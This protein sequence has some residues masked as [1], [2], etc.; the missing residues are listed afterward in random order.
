MN[1][2]ANIT[3]KELKELLTPGTIIS[4]VIVVVM[5]SALGGMMSDQTESEASPK[6]IGVVF[7]E[8]YNPNALDTVIYTG[9]SS[10]VTLGDLI[11]TAYVENYSVTNPEEY[12]HIMKSPFSDSDAVSKELQDESYDAV[13]AIPGDIAANVAAH[14]QTQLQGYYTYTNGGLFSTVT[15]T[16]A[17]NIINKMS[18]LLSTQIIFDNTGEDLNETKFV[19][20]PL[21]PPSN[22]KVDTNHTVINGKLCENV[23]PA[24]IYSSMMGQNMMIPVIVMIVIVMVGSVVISSMGNEKENKT[25][26]TLLTM[27][28]KRTTIVSG[29]LLAAAIMGLVYGI[30]Y[31]AGMMM[32]TNGMTS[33]LGGAKVDLSTYGLVMNPLDWLLLMVILFLSIFSALGI[34]MILGAFTKNYKMAQTMTLPIS[35]LALIPMFI[36][37]FSSWNVLPLIGKILLFIIP[38]THPMMGMDNLMFGNYALVFGGMA[39]LLVFDLI[40]VLVTVKIYNSDIL[41]TGLGQT[42][43]VSKLSKLFKSRKAENEDN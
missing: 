12:I 21:V 11:K 19:Q 2:L 41:I 13:I 26:E 16:I 39:Y 8:T 43:T 37:M 15:G 24:E 34:C 3:K 32:Y 25:L 22:S 33:G 42:K 9:L 29:K 1:H 38:F 23:T 30:C 18:S 20:L 10:N 28:I 17:A 27:P 40:M 36:F 6:N 7:G 35:G 5:F 14:K 4:I 31:L